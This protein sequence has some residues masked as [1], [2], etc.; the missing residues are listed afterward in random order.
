[1]TTY[2]RMCVLSTG[3]TGLVTNQICSQVA[4]CVDIHPIHALHLAMPSLSVNCYP[5]SH[6]YLIPKTHLFAVC[7]LPAVCSNPGYLQRPQLSAVPAVCSSI[8]MSVLAQLSFLRF[9]MSCVLHV[10]VCICSPQ[11]QVVS[12]V[13]YQEDNSP[14]RYNY[15]QLCRMCL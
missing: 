1:M 9:T 2:C 7:T 6:G 12:D 3:K 13:I 5:M 14:I 11:A 15:L 8:L 4:R 10:L